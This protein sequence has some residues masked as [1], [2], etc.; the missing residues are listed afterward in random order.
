MTVMIIKSVNEKVREW[1][2]EKGTFHFISG[3]FE[4][5]TQWS[6][7][8]KPE[9]SQARIAELQSLVGKTGEYEL[10]EDGEWQGIKKWKVKNY[11]GKEQRPAFGGGGGGGRGPYVVAWKQT[12]EGAKDEQRS[13][14]RSVS[15]EYAVAMRA[16]G[17]SED[18]VLSIADKFYAWLQK[19]ATPVSTPPAAAPPLGVP[20]V[21]TGDKIK[22][23]L[24]QSVLERWLEDV[25]KCTMLSQ[26]LTKAKL[27]KEC[28]HD[29]TLDD[30]EYVK[31]SKLCATKAIALCPTMPKPDQAFEACEGFLRELGGDNRL[32]MDAPVFYTKFESARDQWKS[33]AELEARFEG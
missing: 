9:N 11:P 3:T 4:D 28:F 14:H 12:E 8:A 25:P 2:G 5:G 24:R 13:I 26:V 19:T 10:Q 33:M 1:K 20:G 32:G 22:P 17:E 23:P 15:L 16:P 29:R 21:T 31:L 6:L 18:H 30:T 27:I 7:G